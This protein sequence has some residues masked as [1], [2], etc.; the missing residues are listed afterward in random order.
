MFT[1]NTLEGICQEQE[2]E[3]YSNS[4]SLEIPIVTILMYDLLYMCVYILHIFTHT[5]MFFFKSEVI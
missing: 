2:D 3:K 1:V 5:N 4:H